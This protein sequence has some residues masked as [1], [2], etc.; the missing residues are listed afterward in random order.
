MLAL[1]VPTY[2][3]LFPVWEL[4]GV[5]SASLDPLTSKKHKTFHQERL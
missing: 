3:D 4:N 1:Y 5:A 2:I